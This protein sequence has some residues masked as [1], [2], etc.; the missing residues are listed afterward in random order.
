MSDQIEGKKCCVSC[1]GWGYAL[2]RL[3]LG[4]LFFLAALGKF[5]DFRGWV[6]GDVFQNFSKLLPV[7]LLKPFMFGLPFVE[8][9]VGICLLLG[10]F[11]RCAL[12]LA[13]LTLLALNFGL[14]LT[15]QGSVVTDNFIYLLAIGGLLCFAD[16]NA[17]ALDCLRK[18]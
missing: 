15:K 10:L 7:F 3:G 2:P 8:A 17:L 18:R 11:T 6:Y 16:H 12:K 4:M 13:G 5:S 9:I 1:T 14:L